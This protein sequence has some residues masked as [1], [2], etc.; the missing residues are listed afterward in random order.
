M[1]SMIKTV[2]LVDDIIKSSVLNGL[3]ARDVKKV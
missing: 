3:Y 2:F 1:P